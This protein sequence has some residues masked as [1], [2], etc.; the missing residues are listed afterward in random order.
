MP[1]CRD[2]DGY[3]PYVVPVRMASYTGSLTGWGAVAPRIPSLRKGISTG[4][5][6]EIVSLRVESGVGSASTHA[7]LNL[8]SLKTVA[9]VAFTTPD[10][11][12]LAASSNMITNDESPYSSSSSKYSYTSWYT[13]NRPRAIGISDGITALYNY[14]RFSSSFN[15][16]IAQGANQYAWGKPSQWDNSQPTEFSID[17]KSL[18]NTLHTNFA[19]KTCYIIVDVVSIFQAK[20]DDIDYDDTSGI[21]FLHSEWKTYTSSGGC[22]HSYAYGDYNNYGQSTAYRNSGMGLFATNGSGYLA[23]AVHGYIGRFSV[24]D[25]Y[26]FSGT[27]WRMEYLPVMSAGMSGY[28]HLDARRPCIK[29]IIAV[30]DAI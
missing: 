19:G 30:G 22:T 27:G 20:D 17:V 8:G 1:Y 12:R 6:Y 2:S 4:A 21:R 16:I 26:N 28:S 3:F 25:A 7:Y 18:G 15:P 23:H 9:E 24:D 29:F 10:G 5:D 13:S 14:N 11:F